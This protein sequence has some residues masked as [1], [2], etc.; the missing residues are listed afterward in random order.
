MKISELCSPRKGQ[1]I[2]QFRRSL[3][4]ILVLA[5]SLFGLSTSATQPLDNNE[6]LAKI[7]A[8]TVSHNAAL[9]ISFLPD[10]AI[11]LPA[12]GVVYL[13]NIGLKEVAPIFVQPPD[14][15]FTPTSGDRCS[16][17]LAVPRTRKYT[18]N[19]LGLIDT[20]PM[21]DD[22][23]DLGRRATYTSEPP[24][25]GGWFPE[26]GNPGID[27]LLLA[28]E[29]ALEESDVERI[30]QPSLPYVVHANSI[31]RVDAFHPDLV[32]P[33]WDD[34]D[35]IPG[36]TWELGAG[37]Q[38]IEWNA[39]VLRTPATDV[40][41]PPITVGFSTLRY[42][43]P[44]FK[45]GKGLKL[46]PAANRA[47]SAALLQYLVQGGFIAANV[48]GALEREER[49][50]HTRHQ[51]ITVHDVLPPE[52]NFT[53]PI[54]ELE[55]S[56][57]GGA[58]KS[59]V[60][61]DVLAT[62]N[63][64]DPCDRQVSLSD[65]A[66]ALLPIG[67]TEITWT[68]KD[69]GPTVDGGVNTTLASQIVRIA[70]TQAPI[71][72][73]PAGRIV[74]VPAGSAG[75]SAEELMLGS[76]RVVDLADAMPRVANDGPAFYRTDRRESISW[77][78]TDASG[79]QSTA[80]QLVTVKT[81]GTNTAPTANAVTVSTRTSEHVDIVLS[82]SD[83]D[84]IDGR[85]DP[86]SVR[87]ESRP[88]LGE[89]VAPLLPFFIEDYRT[90]PAGPYGEGFRLSNNRSKWLADNVCAENEAIDIDWV[91]NP[92]FVHVTDDGIHYMID[93]FF[94]C[95]TRTSVSSNRRISKWDR[96]GNYLGMMSHSGSAET[97]VLDRDGF[98]YLVNR[99][100][101]GSS[102]S[103]TISQCRTDFD[104]SGQSCD[105]SWRID[106]DSAPAPRIAPVGLSSARVD[107][108]R[109]ILYLTDRIRAF[110]FDIRNS[111]LG[112]SEPPFLA[113]LNNGD[114]LI[115]NAQLNFSC[116]N[117]G[118]NWRGYNLEVDSTGAL[119]ILDSC[120]S[121]VHKFE[122]ASFLGDDSFVPGDYV[123]WLGKCDASTNKAC[124][125]ENGHS[126]GYGCTH[127]T[128]TL[129]QANQPQGSEPGQFNLPAHF[130]MDPND[131]L[132]VADEGNARVQRFAPD[133]T[134][135]GQAKSTGTGINN[136]DEGGFVLGNMGNPRAV[137][138]NSSQF[139]VV[140]Q[141]E[142]F[143]HVF[144]TSPLKDITDSS[145]TVTYASRFDVHT[146]I[147][148]FSFSMNDGLATSEPAVARVNISRAFRDPTAESQS[149]VTVEDTELEITLIGDDPD[150]I[151]GVDFNGLD[152][153]TYQ[154]VQEPKN[155]KLTGSGDLRT[156]KPSQDY[157]GTDTFSYVAYDGN[158][159]SAPAEVTIT[160]SPVDDAPRVASIETPER[161]GLGFPMP[162][163]ATF[164]EDEFVQHTS[165]L[166][167]GD[168]SPVEPRG[169]LFEDED[170]NPIIIDT[171]ITEPQAGRG[172]AVS[173]HTYNA[174]G[175][176]T[177]E[178]CIEDDAG[179]SCRDKS[180][181]ILPLAELHLGTPVDDTEYA[182][183][184][185]VIVTLSLSN[186]EPIGFDGLTALAIQLDQEEDSM[187]KAVAVRSGPAGCTI[188]DQRLNCDL[189]ALGVGD[190]VDIDVELR[191]TGE[192]NFSEQDFLIEFVATTA[193][194]SRGQV[195]VF[196]AVTLSDAVWAEDSDNDGLPDGW[197]RANGLIV[198]VNDADADADLDGLTNAEE[199]EL[200]TSPQLADTD[201]D[202]IDDRT[203]QLAGTD[204]LVGTDTDRDGLPNTDDAD[205]DNDG[206]SDMYELA[207]GLDEFNPLD[208]MQDLDND[209]FS[210]LAEAL[211]DSAADNASSMPEPLEGS[212][213]LFAAVLPLARSTELGE[214]A[215]AFAT[216][217]NAGEEIAEGCAFAPLKPL[218]TTFSYIARNDA[219][220]IANQPVTIDSGRAT[221]FVF[222]FDASAE[223]DERID[224]RFD[225]ANTE[226]APLVPP[227]NSFNLQVGAERTA[228][229]VA[230]AAAG[231]DG[232][233]RL[234]PNNRVGAFAVA[235]V[236][237]GIGDWISAVPVASDGLPLVLG[238]CATNPITAQ[239]LGSGLPESDATVFV[240][241]GDVPTFSVFIQSALPVGLD[242]VANRVFV[243][244]WDSK[245]VVRGSTSVAVT[246][247]E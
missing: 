159:T 232:V 86:L 160:I 52:I 219:T 42:A 225:C 71:L 247:D 123:G 33:Q 161:Y 20:S 2:P 134:F 12:N 177:I 133:G 1:S 31:V 131:I 218:P 204:P 158:G 119:Y 66:P 169:G 190:T 41:L 238:I 99:Q 70:D 3:G 56:D 188:R 127:D 237:V 236:N 140:D 108:E 69:F 210:N 88:Q 17:S 220:A 136:G 37:K 94:K 24:L 13:A 77:S 67:D 195:G 105:R 244:F 207:H 79:N 179:Q 156:Y 166:N 174:A 162:F 144:E 114:K 62:V 212:P 38:R 43:H 81:A 10:P 141:V 184:D 126:K 199:Y 75:I 203:E 223:I 50:V 54:V 111:P 221:N 153:L 125:L 148:E 240:E 93:S 28:A 193:T 151:A 49:A 82:G 233:A 235:S 44:W 211:A 157:F 80:T 142:D 4:L 116:A 241:T 95:Q 14:K 205:D 200:G 84:E 115:G 172:S 143:M 206:M 202:G 97:F 68:V 152:T 173:A 129:T 59:R 139:Y 217:I 124:D 63:A 39:T 30:D 27:V 106:T 146:T 87:I 186:Q 194:P 76:A 229:V 192:Q 98:L 154:I 96:D 164:A 7:L 18:S 170:G 226:P 45:A 234:D 32:R 198:G 147:D 9:P 214:P 201:G 16:V 55:A 213:T 121:R 128:C 216:I 46:L 53:N 242:P 74:E 182:P 25:P 92:E 230:L 109:G 21:T 228:D 130:A 183:T 180:V 51:F 29:L 61:K 149:V 117:F 176:Y 57:L 110:A 48:A 135:A 246:T 150:G 122:P 191:Y 138:V 102:A 163:A 65:D 85:F 187:F 120:T 8:L 90:N 6:Q 89:F 132:Y 83:L 145:A 208:A 40:I 243:E 239:C 137:S 168:G 113:H 227:I 112:Q 175:I 47:N 185:P 36:L 189:L 5:S 171:V 23:G 231:V 222:R 100:G 73:A 15:V 78:A 104:L 181:T 101:S 165:T 245:G 155:G 11:N 19:L 34:G 60:W 22:W 178:W 167:W 118:S 103:A 215:T 58:L 64:S 26:S 224:F 35:H 107:A 197:E 209:G 72:V 196:A 91:N